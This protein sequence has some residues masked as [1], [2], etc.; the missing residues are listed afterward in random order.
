MTTFVDTSAFLAFL[1]ID[2]QN[3]SA[4]SRTWQALLNRKEALVCHNYILVETLSSI[5]KCYG[6]NVL[7]TFQDDV[8]P[9]L[10][11]EW[12]TNEHHQAAASLILTA[13]RR[14]LSLVDCA[15]FNAMRRLGIQTA[16][17]FDPHFAEQGFTVI[18]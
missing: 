10:I 6:M 14:N 8:V 3:H 16:F 18:P 12:L 4:A 11:I 7:R 13:N 2:D 15:S 5:Q 1:D 17:T 9:L